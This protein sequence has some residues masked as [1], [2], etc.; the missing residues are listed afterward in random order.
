MA[1]SPD[2]ERIATGSVD[3]TVRVWTT[4]GAGA[5]LVLRSEDTSGVESVE[6]SPDGK[7]LEDC[8]A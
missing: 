7:R 1:W 5:P 3:G 6:W 8:M 2:G 4:G